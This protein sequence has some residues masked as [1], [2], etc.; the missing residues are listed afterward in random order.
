MMRRDRADG[1]TASIPADDLVT[2]VR[3]LLA[4]RPPAPAFF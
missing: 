4:R 2:A 3:E 1:R